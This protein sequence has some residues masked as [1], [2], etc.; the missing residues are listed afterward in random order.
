[1]LSRRG[2]SPKGSPRR[3]KETLELDLTVSFRFGEEPGDKVTVID[4][5]RVP[6]VGSVFDRRDALLR[7]FVGLLLKAGLSQ[8]RV[9]AQLAPA[10]RVLR[11]GR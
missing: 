6:M 4:D 2:K 7:G 8:P 10:L 9:L 11:H 5:R 3:R 1:M